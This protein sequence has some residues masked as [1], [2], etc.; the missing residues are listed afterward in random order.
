MNLWFWPFAVGM[1]DLSWA[2]GIGP[3]ETVR[4]Y[5]SFYVVTSFGWDAAGALANAALIGLTGV[6]LVPAFRRFAVR[7]RPAVELYD[8]SDLSEGATR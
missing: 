2:P 4:R 6:A 5:W 1:G 3:V 7:L 8:V